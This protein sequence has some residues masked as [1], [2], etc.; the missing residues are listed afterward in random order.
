MQTIQTIQKSSGLFLPE[1]PR[2][3]RYLDDKYGLENMEKQLFSLSND[4]SNNKGNNS[5][6]T[7]FIE[8]NIKLNLAD[9]FSREFSHAVWSIYLFEEC[10]GH[11]EVKI[12]PNSQFLYQKYSG[13]LPE[14]RGKNKREDEDIFY[15]LLYG[16]MILSDSNKAVAV[17]KDNFKHVP[18][19]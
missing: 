8:N 4:Q 15:T 12:I 5:H 11:Y 16:P 13:K 1:A 10:L 6:D 9:V 18:F 3:E 2:F 7:I 19:P 14:L 17:T